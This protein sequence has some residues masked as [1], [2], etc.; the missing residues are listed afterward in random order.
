[1][2]RSVAQAHGWTRS[3]RRADGCASGSCSAAPRSAS[4]RPTSP[5]FL[6]QLATSSK[7][8]PPCRGR[9]CSCRNRVHLVQVRASGRVITILVNPTDA[10]R[11]ARAPFF[12]RMQE[13][14]GK[15]ATRLLAS[16][17]APSLEE[18]LRGWGVA[19]EA[20]DYVTFDHLPRPGRARA[21]SP[22]RPPAGA[23]SCR[24]PGSSPSAPGDSIRWPGSAHR[25]GS[26]GT[27]PSCLAGVPRRSRGGARWRLCRSRRLRDRTDAEAA[28]AM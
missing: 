24:T 11:S 22:R 25:C 23:R 26:S 19:P 8:W 2:A 7:A 14:Y 28:R 4:A 27:S 17:T 6:V 3:A 10:V 18:V 9:M 21:C 16:A 15:L 13:R 12:A 1:M 5:R 20:I